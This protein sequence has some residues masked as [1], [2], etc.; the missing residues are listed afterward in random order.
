MHALRLYSAV[1]ISM[2]RR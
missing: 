1:I 2:I